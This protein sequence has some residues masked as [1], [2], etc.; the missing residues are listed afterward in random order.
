MKEISYKELMF[1]VAKIEGPLFSIKG[2]GKLGKSLIYSQSKGSK[3]AKRYKVPDNPDTIDQKSQRGFM[4][5]A[6]L[7]W[8]TDGYTLLDIEAWNLFASIQKKTLSGYNVFLREYINYAKE[9]YTWHPMWNCVMENLTHMSCDVYVNYYTNNEHRLRS[10]T[11][12]RVMLKSTAPT[13]VDGKYKYAISGLEQNTKYYFY[14]GP[15]FP[16]PSERTGIYSFKT[17]QYTPPPV[18]I[19]SEAVDRTN[20]IGDVHTLVDETNPAN[21]SGTITE[22]EI[23]KTESWGN[24]KVAIFYQVAGNFLS[25]RSWVDLGVP[26]QGYSKHVVS[27]EV[28]EGDYIGICTGSGSV[29]FDYSGV[30]W[31]DIG[32]DQIPCTNVEFTHSAGRAVSVKGTGIL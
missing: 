30:G 3:R 2:V 25:T 15:W 28:H 7:A 5:N 13:R 18:D 11:S 24:I 12:K 20:Y 9:G 21:A 22:V 19:G 27:L 14:V 31:W 6:V 8:K 32:S 16:G 17:L 4:T 1:K 26:P 23:Y 10:G 29:D